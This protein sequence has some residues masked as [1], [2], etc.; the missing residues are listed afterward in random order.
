MLPGL[1]N[2]GIDCIEHGTGLSLHLIDQM[3]DRGVALVP[4]VMQT[5]KFPEYA[6]AGASRFPAYSATMTELFAHRREVLMS[7]YEAGVP[8]YAGSDGGGVARHGNLAGEVL[9][10]A[11]M[12]DPGGD[13]LAAA[14][15]RARE[16]LGFAPRPRPRGRPPTSSSSTPIR[17]GT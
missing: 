9:A 1:I 13:A 5:E 10:L 11:A 8:L 6:E 12:G 2:A 3:A 4:T 7:A 15:W 16:W 14:S 17:C